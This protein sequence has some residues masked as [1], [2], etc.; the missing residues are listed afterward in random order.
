MML[1]IHDSLVS[2]SLSFTRFKLII[3]AP[4]GDDILLNFSN[5]NQEMINFDLV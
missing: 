2:G 1:A 5:I 4:Q 3:Q